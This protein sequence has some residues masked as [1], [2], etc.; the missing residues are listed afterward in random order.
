MYRR[1][2]NLLHSMSAYRRAPSNQVSRAKETFRCKL[3]FNYVRPSIMHLE[4]VVNWLET[5]FLV[6]KYFIHHCFIFRPTDS[7]VSEDARIE[8]R[9]V[10]WQ[11]DALTIRLDLI[12]YG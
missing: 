2:F 4:T 1:I 9:I 10:A 3:F 11:S 8:P 7:T 5:D 6:F 12:H